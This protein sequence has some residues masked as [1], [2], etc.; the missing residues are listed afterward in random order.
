[1]RNCI[2]VFIFINDDFRLKIR[3]LVKIWVTIVL[4]TQKIC[5]RSRIR[6]CAWRSKS[7]QLQYF[8]AFSKKSFT[9]FPLNSGDWSNMFLPRFRFR[10]LRRVFLGYLWIINSVIKSK[11]RYHP[12]F[13]YKCLVLIN[14]WKHKKKLLKLNQSIN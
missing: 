4:S 11:I 2:N 1:M 5:R 7:T 14:L 10:D 9:L 8:S 6:N 12:N 3:I 13:L